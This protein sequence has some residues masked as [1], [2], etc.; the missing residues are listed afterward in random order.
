MT[1]IAEKRECQY[2]DCRDIQDC[3]NLQDQRDVPL[4]EEELCGWVPA[5][6]TQR[7]MIQWRLPGFFSPAVSHC[8]SQLSEML[9]CVQD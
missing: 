1:E 8:H 9:R 4:Q 5:Y 3:L 7:I 2:V 6:Q